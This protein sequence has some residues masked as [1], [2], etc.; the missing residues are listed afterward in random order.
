MSKTKNSK[1][2][3]EI[4]QNF[5]DKSKKAKRAQQMLPLSIKRE[6]KALSQQ[7]LKY[8]EIMKK[9]NL[10]HLPKLGYFYGTLLFFIVFSA[11]TPYP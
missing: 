9:L 4:R 6:I 3:V 2:K 5:D 11:K 7:G 1:A 8:K 10:T